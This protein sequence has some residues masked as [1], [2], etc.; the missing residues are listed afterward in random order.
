MKEVP[1]AIEEWDAKYL[2][3]QQRMGK[4]LEDEMMQN[5]LLRRLPPKFESTLRM[6]IQLAGKETT[7][8]TL[9]Q[10]ILDMCQTYGGGNMATPMD[11]MALSEGEQEQPQQGS[12]GTGKGWSD[13]EVY[14]W[15][16]EH[17]VEVEVDALDRKG[18]GKGF[19]VKGGNKGGGKGAG[20]NGKGKGNGKKCKLCNRLGHEDPDCWCNPKASCY[21]GEEYA[22][23][24]LKRMKAAKSLEEEDEEDAQYLE[25][26]YADL[27]CV[28][29]QDSES[30][31]PD[32]G[33]D[34][35]CGECSESD[36]EEDSPDIMMLGKS[37]GNASSERDPWTISRDPWSPAREI[38]KMPN[39]WMTE[40]KTVM[41]HGATASSSGSPATRSEAT[42]KF[43]E[44]MDR[45][46]K[47]PE[48]EEKDDS[49]SDVDCP[50]AN[51]IQ[52]AATMKFEQE[53]MKLQ[54]NAA[55]I[56]MDRHSKKRA[57]EK[58]TKILECESA[59][60]VEERIEFFEKPDKRVDTTLPGPQQAEEHEF[61]DELRP[62]WPSV[63]EQG[64]SPTDSLQG[65]TADMK[66][67][68]FRRW[69]HMSQGKQKGSPE[70]F[71]FDTLEAKSPSEEV[72]DL[73]DCKAYLIGTPPTGSKMVDVGVQVKPEVRD[74]STQM[75][76]EHNDERLD[77]GD[78]S[79][80]DS[81]VVD[82]VLCKELSM[83]IHDDGK[84][85]SAWSDPQS[86]DGNGFY[87]MKHGL[88]SD[89]GAGDTVG[90]EE[91]F[92][93]YPTNPS[94]GSIR[95]LHY[96]AAGGTKIRNTGQKRVLIFTKEKQLRWCTIQIA[97]VKKT[98]GSE[99]KNNDHGFDVV[100]SKSKGSYMEHEASGERTA[101]RRERGVFV[102]DAWVVPYSMAKTGVVTY[103]DEE[104]KKRTVKVS[105]K[106]E[107]DFIR[108][109]P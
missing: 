95:G 62:P 8:A 90:P 97:K 70:W 29:C 108:P 69:R 99:S 66:V 92:S 7:Y 13:V 27:G 35:L 87:K 81:I 6:Q 45:I 101:L 102:L 86:T 52:S 53:L 30:D 91:E 98:L 104:G 33:G 25:G 94:P 2:K 103:T 85:K 4:E 37:E 17:G 41:M 50:S 5:I 76:N 106:N 48:I 19:K 88:T 67:G 39:T 28:D 59:V 1:T 60:N 12:Q 78:Q 68:R 56:V 20:A 75:E 72:Q 26:L 22:A 77:D 64:S 51:S 80:S 49:N 46:M 36:D 73:Q 9:R 57:K 107:S 55:V 43:D 24:T 89:S 23:K 11:T 93:D 83:A 84:Q 100:Y 109:A 38:P 71:D 61:F 15:L 10:E 14:A 65:F 54:N 63:S 32:D 3:Y 58:S 47:T 44:A 96:V 79:L 34:L 105:R 74:E 21:K 16:V 18:R 31:E 40:E 42:R 82:G